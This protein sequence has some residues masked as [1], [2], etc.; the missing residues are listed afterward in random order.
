MQA[1]YCICSTVNLFGGI[2]F[3][4]SSVYDDVLTPRI[5]LVYNID[6]FTFKLLYSEAFRAPKPWDY[7]YGLGNSDLE[8]EEMKSLEA[9]ASYSLMKN[10]IIDLS[11]YKNK[12]LDLIIQETTNAGSR[13]VNKGNVSTLGLELSLD[14]KEDPFG[15][16]Y[17]YTY[18][19]SEDE[20][21]AMI[22]EIAEHNFN[23]GAT[24]NLL[25]DMRLSLR[26]NY[27]GSRRNPKLISATS[28]NYIDSALIFYSSI[29][30]TGIEK[31]SIC[32]TINNLFNETYY[33]TS[34]RPP[35]RYR[36]P[37]RTILLKVEYNL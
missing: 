18:N 7:G 21:G 11:I 31:F 14:Y 32:G 19:S 24:Y 3:D 30:Y 8:P 23:A 5:A 1:Q 12:L 16:Y 35:D 28:S 22:P 6:K 27:L 37:Q 4:H 25:K 34:N 26:C 15:L 9:A 13:S 10:F 17:N 2:R 20:T 33:H 36:Q 29:I